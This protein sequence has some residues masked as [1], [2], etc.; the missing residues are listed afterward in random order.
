MERRD[1]E[2]F[3]TLAEELH[4]GRTAERL[5]LSQARVS[6]TIKQLERRIG[7]ALFERTSRRVSLTPIGQRLRDDLL[8]A[9]RQIEEAIDRA[10]AA[11]RGVRGTLRLAFESPPMADLLAESIRALRAAQPGLEVRL[12]EAPFTD[13]LSA[14]SGDADVLVAALPVDRPGLVAGP[15]VRAEPLVLAVSARHPFARLPSVS[16]EDLA[17]D[18]VFH[19]AWPTVAAQDPDLPWRTPGGRPIPRGGAFGTFQELLAAVAAGDGVCPVAAH[20]AEYFARPTLAFVPMDGVPP[21]EWGVVWRAAAETAQVRAF[22]EALV[23]AG[24]SGHAS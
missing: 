18:T 3:L 2:V 22:A 24:Q 20:A 12:R 14:L 17:R 9:H 23:S 8:P 11:G 15:V 4:F 13:P 7:A 16:A 6:Q 1:I 21:I 5:R 19:A 10:I